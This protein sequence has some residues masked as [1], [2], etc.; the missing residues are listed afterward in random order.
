MAYE[1]KQLPPIERLRD[2]FVYD[3]DTGI[4]RWKA[5]R[6]SVKQGEIAG[7][8][9]GGG[10]Y[11]RIMID[12]QRVLAHRVAWKLH[13]GSEPP[14]ILDH[15]D[16]DPTNNRVSNLR[17]ATMLENG[18]NKNGTRSSTGVRGVTFC[19]QTEKY[20]AVIRTGGKNICLGRYATATE[21]SAAY[22]AA[23]ASIFGA[24]QG[25]A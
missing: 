5:K 2:Q 6:R 16:G 8:A 17:A 21:A 23:A 10:G 25:A 22:Q 24:F 7:T 4:I 12:R 18:R 1:A 9:I 15:I 19:K 3:P 11:I 14:P 13:Y 20:R